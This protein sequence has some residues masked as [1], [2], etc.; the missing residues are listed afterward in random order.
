MRTRRHA[1]FT[2][3]ELLVVIAII[4]I[5]I[6]LLLP[7]VQQAREAARRT[8]CKN[9]L[10]QW[11]LALHNYH[12]T[13]NTFPQGTMGLN[14]NN[15]SNPV[16]NFPFHVHLLPF[17]DQAPLYNQFNPA[18][19]YDVA[20]NQALRNQ[21]FEMLFCPSAI[22]RDRQSDTITQGYTV[23]YYGVAGPKGPKPAP[24]TGNWNHEGNTTTDHG[25]IALTGLLHRNRHY[26]FRD[27]TDGSSNTLVIGEVSEARP[28]SGWSGSY[29]PWIQGASNANANVASYCCKNVTH[30]IGNSGYNGGNASRLFNDVRFGSNH[31]GGAQFLLSDGSVHF[32][33]ENIDFATYQAAASRDD[34]LVLPLF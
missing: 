25:G 1:G 21:R 19:F 32:I 29:R 10:K 2:L 33:S 17:L 34:G 4:A 13:H 16:N 28:P 22:I 27:I 24:L 20:P 31:S 12:D 8:Q 3:I 15:T 11:G 14:N 7:A 30:P 18:K 23:H 9:N 26:S 5:L 6:A